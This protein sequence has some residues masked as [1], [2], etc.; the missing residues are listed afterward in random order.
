MNPTV[1]KLTTG[2]T[3]VVYGAWDRQIPL[4]MG[5]HGLQAMPETMPLSV[6]P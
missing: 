1:C 3:G 5:T 2:D 4:E 6:C